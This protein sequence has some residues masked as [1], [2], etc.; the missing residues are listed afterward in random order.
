MAYGNSIIPGTTQKIGLR[1]FSSTA[2]SVI[3]AM[4]RMYVDY[5]SGLAANPNS[6][7]VFACEGVKPING[8]FGVN[9][10]PLFV[11]KSW[12]PRSRVPAFD[13]HANAAPAYSAQAKSENP[14]DGFEDDIPF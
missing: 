12:V 6:V 9:Y 8:A 14:A 3:T 11:L 2:N 7:P 1:E 10:E 13:E 5:E 4:V